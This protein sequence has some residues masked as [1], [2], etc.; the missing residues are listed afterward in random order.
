[1]DPALERAFAGNG[2]FGV[3]FAQ[4]D[5]QE[6]SSPAGMLPPDGQGFAVKGVEGSFMGQGRPSIRRGQIRRLLRRL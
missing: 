6:A 1:V 5:A 3:A 2:Q 4:D